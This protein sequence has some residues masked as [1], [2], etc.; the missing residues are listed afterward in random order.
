MSHRYTLGT[1]VLGA[2]LLCV[3]SAALAAELSLTASRLAAGVGEKIEISFER[4]AP[5]G[6]SFLPADWSGV[7]R[8][9]TRCGGEQENRHDVVSDVAGGRTVGIRLTH[10]GV[11]LVGVDLTPALGTMKVGDL[12]KLLSANLSPDA[13]MKMS[14]PAA[15][16][17]RTK[18]FVT[19]N[20]LIRADA[21]GLARE[22]SAVAMSKTG[23]KSE[24]RP[25]FDPTSATVG[26]D[27]PMRAYADGAKVEGLIV[28]AV[29]PDG[30]RVERTTDATG[31]FVLPVE[32]SGIW[33]VS[34]SYARPSNMD[35]DVSWEAFSAALTFEVAAKSGE[36]Q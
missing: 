25:L 33:R 4:P 2:T 19:A 22:I 9:F 20:V 34:F 24:I 29:L 32:Q 3:T 5:D 27:L 15:G 21:P 16:D 17:V 7:S 14:L 8:V 23:Q 6:K 30:K 11:L 12:Q 28:H 26:S 18:S 35:G 1:A 13:L 10:P 36:G 31:T